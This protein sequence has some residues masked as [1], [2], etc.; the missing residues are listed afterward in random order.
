MI[1]R[2]SIRTQL[3]VVAVLI[4]AAGVLWVGHD[5]V[6]KVFASILRSDDAAQRGA[7][8]RERKV[9]VVLERV[10][11]KADDAVIEAIATARARRFI[12]LYPEAAGEVAELAVHA[13]KRVAVGDVILKLESRSAQ[14]A[15]DLA[16]VK[17]SEAET[18]L[19]RM[20]QLHQRKVNPLAKVDDARNVLE[21]ARLE[22]KQA[23]E[24]LSDR[25]M[26][27]PL[28][29]IVGIPKVEVGDRVTT[30]TPVV[31]LDDRRELLVE[32]EVAEEYLSR[33][34]VGQKIL[35]RTPSFPERHFDGVVERIDTR[36]NPTSRTVKIRAKIPN[37]DDLLRPG[38]SFAVQLV[39]PGK[40]YPMVPELALQWAKGESFV[41]KI[42]NGVAQKVIVR[43]IKRENDVILV[44]GDIADG[45][46]V[47]VEGVQRLRPGRAV[48]FSRA[49]AKPNN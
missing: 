36:V 30:T 31:T 47:V 10:G 5:H 6:S 21:R 37:G 19:G 48:R 25:T 9:P 38:M 29:G 41:W 49:N 22:L 15:V 44:K 3:T 33:L 35:A 34:A 27:A 2:L 28:K 26:R 32:I 1:K 43:T 20:Q 8:R 39:I 45:D 18:M 42:K 23:Q 11:T 17:V 16:K 40:S 46:M 13:G 4:G 14:L 24:A 12:T 7:G